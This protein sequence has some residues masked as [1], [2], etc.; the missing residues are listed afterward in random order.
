[1]DYNATFLCQVS[2]WLA[3]EGAGHGAAESKKPEPEVMLRLD[4]GHLDRILLHHELRRRFPDRIWTFDDDTSEG[5]PLLVMAVSAAERAELEQ[6]EPA[7]VLADRYVD[8]RRGFERVLA[9]LA[10]AKRPLIGHNCMTDL[11]LLFGQFVGPLPAVYA[12]FKER[13]HRLLPVVFDTKH[14]A[15]VEGKKRPRQLDAGANLER[16]YAALTQTGS[17]GAAGS[18]PPSV[19]FAEDCSRYLP[20]YILTV[21]T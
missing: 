3:G 19:E 5:A 18:W 4:P 20:T 1:L 13:L 8:S 16:L 17:V 9:A 21:P 6:E 12:E 14:M 7:A 10:A 11:H 15:A 2:G